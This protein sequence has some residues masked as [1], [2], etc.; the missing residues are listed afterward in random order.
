MKSISPIWN[1]SCWCR[2]C[3]MPSIVPCAYTSWPVRCPGNKIAILAWC[4]PKKISIRIFY[5]CQNKKVNRVLSSK[6]FD[7]WIQ[8]RGL[9]FPSDVDTN[10]ETL[11]S[12]NDSGEKPLKTGI[13]T[14]KFGKG[15]F[16]YTGLSFFRELPAGIPGAYRLLV[17]MI[18]LGK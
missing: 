3:K 16:T 12:C 7:N 8:E 10:Y 6:D 9:Y 11:I 2:F 15:N 18:S 17:N 13:I 1:R 14:C 4:Q 5:F